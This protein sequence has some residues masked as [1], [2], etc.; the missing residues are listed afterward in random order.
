MKPTPTNSFE[1]TFHELANVGWQGDAVDQGR[2]CLAYT[3]NEDNVHAIFADRVGQLSKSAEENGLTLTLEVDPFGNSYAVLAGESDR[4]VVICSHL[5]SVPNG[6]K[7]D[8]VLGVAAGLDVLQRFVDQGKKPQKTIRVAAF[9]GEESSATGH[10]CLGSSLATGNFDLSIL[11]ERI[12]T[13]SGM[14]LFNVLAERGITE[15]ALQELKNNPYI[16]G[17]ILD[18]VLETHIEQSSVLESLDEPIGVVVDGIGG[19][20]RSDLVISPKQTEETEI[21]ECDKIL[22]ITINGKA[23]HS[24]GLPM[25]SEVILDK[26][27][28]LR[29]DALAV[30]A[31]IA[32][33][34]PDTMRLAGISVPDGG[35][36][37][38]VQRECTLEVLVPSDFTYENIPR[39]V[40]S[41]LPDGMT[42]QFDIQNN[43]NGFKPINRNTAKSAIDIIIKCE[44]IASEMARYTRGAVRATIGKLLVNGDGSIELGIDQRRLNN[45]LAERMRERI[46]GSLQLISLG[47]DVGIEEKNI[48]LAPATPLSTRIADVMRR[49]YRD[50]FQEKDPPEMGSMPGQDAAKVIRSKD[51]GKF[52]DGGMIFIRS[53]NGG[54]SHHPEELSS[55]DDMQ[56][57]CDLLFETVNRL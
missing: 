28:N 14:N 50:L 19:A 10:V 32:K 37:N 31:K 47:N 33:D 1:S 40:H 29:R 36:Y 4:E 23:G 20:R 2:D 3:E 41:T 16:K 56:K 5:D 15:D 24:G 11:K 17:D 45:E 21:A 6:G 53:L 30:A 12:H 49:S 25:N 52:V 27:M 38:V 26:E 46:A 18:A 48:I 44:E 55:M 22:Q 42:A 8:G 51:G 54:V 7:Y 13:D 34:L 9:R 43:K 57:A 39:S 35:S